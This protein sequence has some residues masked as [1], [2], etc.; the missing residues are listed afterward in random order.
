MEQTYSVLHVC[1]ASP[2]FLFGLNKNIWRQLYGVIPTWGSVCVH[3]RFDYTLRWWSQPHWK[4]ILCTKGCGRL[5]VWTN[6]QVVFLN[7]FETHTEVLSMEPDI[8]LGSWAQRHNSSVFRCFL[9][10]KKFTLKIETGQMTWVI[11]IGSD[12]TLFK[13]LSKATLTYTSSGE[14]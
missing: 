11:H 3:F 6:S 13:L 2:R 9:T 14:V 8:S 4:M 7:L 1:K 5:T 12:F 10:Q